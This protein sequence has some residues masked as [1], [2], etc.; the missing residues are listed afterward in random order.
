MDQVGRQQHRKRSAF[1]ALGAWLSGNGC[2]KQLT[3]EY[4][5]ARCSPILRECRKGEAEGLD[6]SPAKPETD[7]EGYQ[8]EGEGEGLGTE[9][10]SSSSSGSGSSGSG[11]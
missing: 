8:P 1:L 4:P 5:T 2:S 6:I 3:L 11:E 9:G 7:H 10:G